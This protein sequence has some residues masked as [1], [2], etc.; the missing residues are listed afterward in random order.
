MNLNENWNR[1][2][3]PIPKQERKRCKECLY[4]EIKDG[5]YRCFKHKHW[6]INPDKTNNDNAMQIDLP[7]FEGVVRCDFVPKPK[8]SERKEKDG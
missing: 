2:T 8:F 7:S 1:Q 6:L 4:F 5:V 3:D